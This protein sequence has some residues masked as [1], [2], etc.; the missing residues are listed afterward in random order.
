MGQPQRTNIVLIGM[1][2]SG[3]STVGVLLA[4]RLRKSFV[5][6]DLYLQQRC[7]QSL[8][9][10]LASGGN[11]HFRA[12]EEE[13]ILGLDCTDTVIATG[14]SVVYSARAMEHLRSLGVVV[15]L[16]AELEELAERIGDLDARAV[17]RA[18]GQSLASLFA[19]R[20]PLYARYADV[21]VPVGGADQQ[22]VVERVVRLLD[23]W[24]GGW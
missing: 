1:P 2:A 6:T 17:V 20:A 23:E 12:L 16:R 9:E 22:A 15:Y 5:D 8:A 19:E 4:K 11:A 18:A 13:A 21:V 7:G 3:K 24:G 10:I 14:G